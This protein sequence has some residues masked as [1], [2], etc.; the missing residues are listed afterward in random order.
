MNSFIRRH[1]RILWTTRLAFVQACSWIS[2]ALWHVQQ[3]QNI[4]LYA[5]GTENLW[6]LKP[7]LFSGVSI[8]E[9]LCIPKTLWTSCLK[10]H[11]RQFHPIFATDVLE[12]IDVRIRYWLKRSKV[13]AGSVT[14]KTG[15]IQYFHN[16][17][18]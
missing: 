1:G 2:G 17:W 14:R 15:W 11:W 7:I 6:C 5:S 4:I 16:Y 12:F 18:S 10:N 8:C 13:T 3:F 9:L